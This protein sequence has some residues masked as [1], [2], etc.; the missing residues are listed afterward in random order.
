M[1]VFSPHVE[2]LF[3]IKVYVFHELG[4]FFMRRDVF[5]LKKREESIFIH[6]DNS[7]L[8]FVDSYYQTI[9]LGGVLMKSLDSKSAV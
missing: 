6:E 2:C 3:S 9:K 7:K 8:K 4:L 1:R 5:F